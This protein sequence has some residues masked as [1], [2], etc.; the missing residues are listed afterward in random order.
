MGPSL[1]EALFVLLFLDNSVHAQCDD[2]LDPCLP[3]GRN[4]L[5]VRVPFSMELVAEFGGAR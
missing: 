3:L 2:P 4:R 5:W 1:W